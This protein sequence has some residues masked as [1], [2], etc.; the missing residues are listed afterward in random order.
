MNFM[1]KIMVLLFSII[2][3]IFFSLTVTAEDGK[4]VYDKKCASCHGKDGKGN[5]A[6]VKMLKVDISL[7]DIVD[8]GTL[9]KS[10]DELVSV[11][12]KGSNKMPAYGK[13]LRDEEINGVVSYIRSLAK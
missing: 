8:K 1:K 5:A 13:E 2:F 4:K 6:M 3:I 9:G 7:L 11:T 10:D 12:T